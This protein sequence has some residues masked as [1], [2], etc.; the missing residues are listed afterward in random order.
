MIRKRRMR[1]T[2]I[3]LL[4]VIAIIAILAALLLPA[5]GRAR[6]QARTVSCA[7]NQRQ[8]ALG[9][10]MYSMDCKD[11]YP[12]AVKA[13]Y[14]TWVDKVYSY[15]SPGNTLTGGY[16]V[17]VPSKL[18]RCP[19]SNQREFYTTRLSYGFHMYLNTSESA[20]PGFV[21]KTV[22]IPFPSEALLLSELY[23]KY[24]IGNYEVA[25]RHG[26]RGDPDEMT[27]YTNYT[28]LSGRA[29]MATVAGNVVKHTARYFMYAYR[30]VYQ[31]PTV[32]L[33]YNQS[34][35]KNP[36]RPPMD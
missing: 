13:S 25:P 36:K 20:T 29:N 12:P 22:N 11:Y 9:L 28:Y 10:N 17:Y 33:P 24:I 3:E 6:E 14:Y 2:L 35:S 1:F 4:V 19:S 27:S 21:P 5:L 23:D 34:F 8:I 16:A 7:G 26:T 31:D 18:F 15:V 30:P 32:T